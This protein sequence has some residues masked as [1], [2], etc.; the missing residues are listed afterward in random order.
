MPIYKSKHKG[1]TVIYDTDRK[2]NPFMVPN[3]EGHKR[4]DYFPT[5]KAAH[6]HIDGTNLAETQFNEPLPTALSSPKKDSWGHQFSDD[7]KLCHIKE[8]LNAGYAEVAVCLDREGGYTF[9]HHTDSFFADIPVNR[10]LARQHAAN[11]KEI[12]RLQEENDKIVEAMEP[13][14][15]PAVKEWN[16]KHPAKK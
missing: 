2:E 14:T 13:F 11:E 15:M 5:E 3:G 16:K 12:E 9:R 6:D 10:N 4:Y 7:L 1:K 8:V